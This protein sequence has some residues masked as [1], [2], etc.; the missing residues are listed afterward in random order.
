MALTLIKHRRNSHLGDSVQPGGMRERKEGM[1]GREG[2]GREGGG[3]KEGREEGGGRK[4]G[5]EEGG[6]RGKKG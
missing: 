2:G 3:R 4:E 6:G 5:R 1:R